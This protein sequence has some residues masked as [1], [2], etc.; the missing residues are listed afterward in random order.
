MRATR[1]T[2]VVAIALSSCGHD[3][4]S[5]PPFPM[6]LKVPSPVVHEETPHKVL[7]D[8]AHTELNAA[9]KSLDSIPKLN[10]RQ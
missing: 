2:I 6:L 3:A 1:A 4:S 7:S 10:A 5:S 9:K 8:R